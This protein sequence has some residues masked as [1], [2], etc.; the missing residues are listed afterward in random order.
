MRAASLVLTALVAALGPAGCQVWTTAP[1]LPAASN[2]IYGEP[3]LVRL[4]LDDGRV[5]NLRNPAIQNDSINGGL[6]AGGETGG[7]SIAFPLSKV[8]QLDRKQASRGRTIAL[9]IGIGAAALVTYIALAI[10][11]FSHLD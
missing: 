1:L 8:R 6:I 2:G 11:G 5:V 10:Q 3:R 4:T 9:V 7:F